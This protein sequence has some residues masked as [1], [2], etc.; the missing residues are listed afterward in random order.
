L[1]EVFNI[2][3]RE[4][5]SPYPD[6][7]SFQEVVPQSVVPQSTDLYSQRESE[8]DI[9]GPNIETMISSTVNKILD[10][11]F[12]SLERKFS[13][14]EKILTDFSPQIVVREVVPREEAIEKIKEFIGQTQGEFY[15]DEIA[16][17]LHLDFQLV[18]DIVN[19]LIENE[20]IEESE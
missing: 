9:S 11:K 3:K 14:F 5:I 13:D 6:P 10:E 16:D 17:K 2:F 7:Q 1:K 8:I 15:P 18:M 12:T 20:M 19:E 4:L